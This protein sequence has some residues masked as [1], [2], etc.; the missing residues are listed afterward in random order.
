[1]ASDAKIEAR[2]AKLERAAEALLIAYAKND[3]GGGNIDWDD[4]DDAFALATKALPGRY[5]QL[6]KQIEK[7]N[8]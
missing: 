2:L 4:L 5:R 1:M 7:E 6:V 3:D 8:A